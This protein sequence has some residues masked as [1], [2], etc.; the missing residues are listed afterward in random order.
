MSKY[1]I[2][3]K[4]EKNIYTKNGRK[5]LLKNGEISPREAAFMKGYEQAGKNTNES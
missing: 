1:K 5:R 2:K 4:Q 3:R